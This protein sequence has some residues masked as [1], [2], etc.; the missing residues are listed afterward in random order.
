MGYD[1]SGFEESGSHFQRLRQAGYDDA[2]RIL[3]EKK[4]EWE[5]LAKALIEYETLTGEEIK[6][7]VAGKKIDKSDELPVGEDKRT[8]SSIPEL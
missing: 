3:T 2:K 5:T 1:R 7:V 4:K 6:D 8:S